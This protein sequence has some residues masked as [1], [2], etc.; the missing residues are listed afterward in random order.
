MFWL[1][2]RVVDAI[3]GEDDARTG[4]AITEFVDSSLAAMPQ[5]LRLGVAL[6]SLGLGAWVRLRHGPNPDADAIRRSI[7]GWE[8]NP[9][10]VV[11]QYPRLLSSLVIFA[12]QELR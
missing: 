10:G 8:H 6:E 1:E 2:G 9:I 5:H 11:R 4:G 3:A 7:T 12:Q